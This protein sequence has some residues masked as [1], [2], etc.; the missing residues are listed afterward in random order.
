MM[1]PYLSQEKAFFV[2]AVKK[3]DSS[4][5]NF[6]DLNNLNYLVLDDL[7]FDKILSN[8]LPISIVINF[9]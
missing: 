6:W 4:L 3:P 7:A 5:A 1:K 8:L 9:N 2:L